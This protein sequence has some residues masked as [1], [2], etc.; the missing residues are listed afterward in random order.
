M[1]LRKAA[2]FVFTAILL[3]GCG[4]KETAAN[5]SAVP[6]FVQQTVQTTATVTAETEPVPAYYEPDALALQPAETVLLPEQ[7]NPEAVSAYFMSVPVPDAVFARINGISYHE[8]PHISRD[9]LRYLRV[10]HYNPAGEICTGEMLCNK[11][12]AADLLDI[13]QA[14]YNAKY[15]IARMI[16]VD[17]YGG[18][19][20]ASMAANNTSCFNYR[21]IAGSDA[22]SYHALGLAIDINPLFNPYV[23]VSADGSEHIEPENSLAYANR[24][25]FF[26][27]KIDH[28]D[29]CYRLFTEHGFEWGGDWDTPKDYQHFE[30]N[31]EP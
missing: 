23:T 10:L 5:E 20:A 3:C 22:L 24:D 6:A 29:L 28:D 19:D 14:L 1:K 12:I 16:L 7:I 2:L 30:K 25:M 17:D 11:Q 8:N 21:V 31:A 27:M 26:P 13:F 4:Q 15:P 18:D 9:E